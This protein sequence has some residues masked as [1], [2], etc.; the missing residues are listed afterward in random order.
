MADNLT[1]A[2]TL[3]GSATSLARS[4]SRN[5]PLGTST[6]TEDATQGSVRALD[7][8]SVRLT[9]SDRGRTLAGRGTDNTPVPENG[10]QFFRARAEAVGG[11]AE[12]VTNGQLVRSASEAYAKAAELNAR[13]QSETERK[14][15]DA[16]RVEAQNVNQ[17][18]DAGVS[19]GGLGAAGPGSNAQAQAGASVLAISNERTRALNAYRPR[20]DQRSSLL[21]TPSAARRANTVAAG[22]NRRQEEVTQQLRTE[23]LA[24]SFANR[25][26]GLRSYSRVA[27]YANQENPAVSAGVSAVA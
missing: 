21:S 18:L 3:I 11:A 25:D 26:A 13:Q 20:E 22:I 10:L 24:R 8:E 6:T 12:A 4:G 23:S 1:I 2:K 9:I 5:G 14:E 19:N 16:S 27:G 17:K 15:I 7:G